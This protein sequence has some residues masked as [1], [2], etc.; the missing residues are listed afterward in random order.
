MQ[1]DTVNQLSVPAD[2]L[3]RIAVI[4]QDIK[5]LDKKEN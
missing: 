1:S 4:F 2:D 5:I 3:K